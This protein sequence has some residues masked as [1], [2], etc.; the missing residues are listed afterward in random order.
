M[1]SSASDP[2]ETAGATNLHNGY[3]ASSIAP[4]DHRTTSEAEPHAYLTKSFGG[5]DQIQVTADTIVTKSAVV[6][7]G[8][9]AGNTGPNHGES[10]S[11]HPTV[12]NTSPTLAV[13][14]SNCTTNTSNGRSSGTASD[15]E[16]EDGE[17]LSNLQSRGSPAERNKYGKS[18]QHT[19]K[20]LN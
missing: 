7:M 2:F 9:N 14:A 1:P 16:E 20:Q 17:H 5:K 18:S 4:L 8:Y 12:N 15:E 19:E 3:G 6:R 10:N 13:G 11:V